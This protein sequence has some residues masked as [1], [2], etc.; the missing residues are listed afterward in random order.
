MMSTPAPVTSRAVLQ[1]VEDLRLH[2]DIERGGR[3][4]TDQQVRIVGDG[5]RDDHP[6]ALAAG[7]LVRERL[8]PPLG[9]GDADQFEQLDGAGSC[10]PPADVALVHLDRLGDLITDG[11]DGRERRHR[12]LEH[13]ADGLAADLR[14]LAGPTIR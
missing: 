1:H 14:H 2:G 11:V 9:L 4:V 6:L 12:V 10:R 8:R 13:R 3:L 7:Q 5:D